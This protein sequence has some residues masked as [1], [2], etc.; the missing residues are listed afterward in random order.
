MAQESGEHHTSRG[1][2]DER[3]RI[4]K[5]ASKE[6]FSTGQVAGLAR[7]TRSV[8]TLGST[9]GTGPRVVNKEVGQPQLRDVPST[10]LP[11]IVALLSDAP[12]AM[13]AIGKARFPG[14]G[15]DSSI[16]A[17]SEYVQLVFAA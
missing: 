16:F 5:A 8:S 3:K 13:P 1:P 2:S 11:W 6:K 9:R 17:H 15:P 7:E 10:M 14:C 4:V 12:P